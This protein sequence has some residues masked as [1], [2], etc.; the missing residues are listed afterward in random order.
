MKMT[1][2]FL[3]AFVSC[4]CIAS[5]DSRAPINKSLVLVKY[6]ICSIVLKMFYQHDL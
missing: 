5:L 4:M 6:F 3:C 1:N 2:L